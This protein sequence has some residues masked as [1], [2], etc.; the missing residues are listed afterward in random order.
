MLDQKTRWQIAQKH[1]QS[2]WQQFES[3]LRPDYKI[4]YYQLWAENLKNDLAEDLIITNETKILEIGS[5]AAGI[6]SR[7]KSNFRFAIDPLEELFA[8]IERFKKIRDPAV[9][10]MTA[11]GEELPFP[12]SFFDLIILDN[13]LDHCQNP[14]KI[15]K[16]I[17][18][19]LRPSGIAYLRINTYHIWGQF[20]RKIME[21]FIL[22]KGHPHTYS[23]NGIMNLFENYQFKVFHKEREG[24]YSHWK[25]DWRSKKLKQKIKAFLFVTADPFLA[26][27]KK[28]TV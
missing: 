11:K 16:E 28:T 18:R 23:K 22:D 19:V 4:E 25:K 12:D 20:V 8:S 17:H 1:E 27:F 24:F 5:G 21:K 3:G 13:V 6:V 2:W 7:L 26:C 15:I 9:T 14:Q 10:Y